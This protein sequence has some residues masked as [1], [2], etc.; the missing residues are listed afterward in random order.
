M[1]HVVDASSFSQHNGCKQESFGISVVY[2]FFCFGFAIECVKGAVKNNECEWW[3]CTLGDINLCEWRGLIALYKNRLLTSTIW[4]SEPEDGFRNQRMMSSGVM[5]DSKLR[6]CAR[7]L[8]ASP[9]R[10]WKQR[11]HYRFKITPAAPMQRFEFHPKRGKWKHDR[12]ITTVRNAQQDTSDLQSTSCV[13]VIPYRQHWL[14]VLARMN[15]HHQRPLSS[16]RT[17]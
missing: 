3:R 6:P 5:Q 7:S 14:F 11:C 8:P 2:K 13:L 9:L 1:D 4:S 10:E 15:K 12:A 17:C 16:W